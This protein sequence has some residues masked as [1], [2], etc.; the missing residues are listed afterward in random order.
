MSNFSCCCA[1]QLNFCLSEALLHV[2]V[3]GMS[4]RKVSCEAFVFSVFSRNEEKTKPQTWWSVSSKALQQLKSLLMCQ[5]KTCGQVLALA[6]VQVLQNSGN[7]I[8]MVFLRF[9]TLSAL[10]HHWQK[11]II[12]RECINIKSAHVSALTDSVPR[13]M[14]QALQSISAIFRNQTHVTWLPAAYLNH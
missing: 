12:Y 1:Q 4:L 10:D 13:K 7:L 9:T 8:M 3:L 5:A 6:L 14:G 11:R 2:P